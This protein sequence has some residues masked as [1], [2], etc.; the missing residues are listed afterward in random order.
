[1]Q[2]P[3][4]GHLFTLPRDNV[5]MPKSSTCCCPKSGPASSLWSCTWRKTPRFWQ[6]SL[7]VWQKMILGCSSGSWARAVR[8]PQCPSP[9]S[10]GT[11]HCQA[12]R[13]GPTNKSPLAWGHF[14]L[15][16]WALAGHRGPSSSQTTIATS[17]SSSGHGGCAGNNP[18]EAVPPLPGSQD[19]I[20][21]PR[22]PGLHSAQ[23]REAP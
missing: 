17:A 9:I 10:V 23:H 4:Y 6:E 18:A 8:S 21:T 5:T 7:S 12:G 14:S 20:K 2:R 16:L 11:G 1:M 15:P 3:R 13:A 22:E 19:P